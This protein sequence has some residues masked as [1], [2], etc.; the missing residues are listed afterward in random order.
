MADFKLSHTAEE[1]DE[2]LNR[3]KNGGSG[4]GFYNLKLTTIIRSWPTD[5]NDDLITILTAEESAAV[6]SAIASGLPILLE[7]SI[8][9]GEGE[10]TA[11]V[12]A[13]AYIMR[14]PYMSAIAC[15][16]QGDSIT[17]AP[18][19]GGDGSWMVQYVRR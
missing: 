5:D 7:G 16:V 19:F 1:V 9:P 14:A 6:E 2:L 17:I 4:G 11:T 15:D 12:R 8:L 10:V 3:V 18:T 13:F